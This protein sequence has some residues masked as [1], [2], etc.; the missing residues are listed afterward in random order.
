MTRYALTDNIWEQLEVTLK[1]Y[2]CN[3]LTNDRNVM[4]AILWKLRT[5]APWED[6]PQDFC[7]WEKAYN[8]FNHWATKGLWDKFF[9]S[10]EAKLIRSGYSSME[11]MSALISIRVELGMMK[12]EPSETLAEDQPPIYTLPPI[13]MEIRSI[14]KSLDVKSTTPKLHR[15]S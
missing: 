4:E 11:V 14:L 3:P 12:N 10:Y 2:E 13:R 7:P 5:G 1:K 15:S 8:R 6:I 9:L